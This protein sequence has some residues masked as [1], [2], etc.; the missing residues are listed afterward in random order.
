[1]P[2]DSDA[3]RRLLLLAF[4]GHRRRAGGG[5]SD[6][7]L[8]PSQEADGRDRLWLRRSPHDRGQPGALETLAIETLALENS[9][10]RNTAATRI[11]ATASKL[12]EVR[13]LERRLDALESLQASRRGDDEVEAFPEEG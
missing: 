7:W 2:G 11:V 9:I 12:L 13:E 8:S 10:S 1:V 6:R 4:A 5:S 3:R